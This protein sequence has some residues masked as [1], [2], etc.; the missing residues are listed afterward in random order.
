M[1]KNTILYSL[2]W[3]LKLCIAITLL[4][5]P[6]IAQ[7]APSSGDTSDT[8]AVPVI[9][10][11]WGRTPHINDIN[12]VINSLQIS[13][14]RGKDLLKELKIA[15]KTDSDFKNFKTIFKS[16]QDAYFQGEFPKAKELFESLQ[17]NMKNEHI[18]V[19]LNPLIQEMWFKSIIYM[20]LLAKE[21]PD[22]RSVESYLKEASDSFSANSL[23]EAEF[24][25]WLCKLYTRIKTQTAVRTVHLNLNTSY[26][27]CKPVLDGKE[28]AESDKTYKIAQ[29]H[30]IISA[31]C[32]DKTSLTSILEI[33]NRSTFWNAI[34]LKK[35]ELSISPHDIILN[36]L[37]NTTETEIL[38]DLMAITAALKTESLLVIVGKPTKTEYWVV[39]LHTAEIISRA[40][41]P[42][43]SKI[44]NQKVTAI[45]L[46]KN[47]KT[48]QPVP[49]LPL[50]KRIPWYKKPAPWI[51]TGV[52]IS[53][54]T[55]GLVLGI[56]NGNYST[57]EPTA[58]FLQISGGIIT[59]TGVSLFFVPSFKE[60][61]KISGGIMVTSVNF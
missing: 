56:K 30:H 19:L 38:S 12:A 3:C 2:R 51:V 23:S 25:P 22:G 33:K 55:A 53:A 24:P 48:E 15:I 4:L 21:I 13:T 10:I 8:A 32:K 9:A 37:K 14:L 41:M 54:I 39:K 11:N 28:L 52:G 61:Q 31:K 59:A 57:T 60:Q 16:G 7:T 42:E 29:G 35:T 1:K 26:K 18:K 40:S 36:T 6:A 58:I 20:A 45:K 46:I 27:N 5:T 50:K 49:L 34:W 43:N 17:R 47:L 44:S